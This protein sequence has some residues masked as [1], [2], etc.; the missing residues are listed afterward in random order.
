MAAE[1]TMTQ[2]ANLYKPTPTFWRLWCMW[3]ERSLLNWTGVCLDLCKGDTQITTVFSY[4]SLKY[5][6]CNF[7]IFPPYIINKL[8]PAKETCMF[9]ANP[10][11]KLWVQ[12]SQICP[13]L[14]CQ[15]ARRLSSVWGPKNH[16][17]VLGSYPEG[18]FPGQCISPIMSAKAKEKERAVH[19][20]SLVCL[21]GL[22][23]R[24]GSHGAPQN[25]VT[26]INFLA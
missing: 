21:Q 15:L 24:G 3:R 19:C 2:Q 10:G 26:G 1:L 12:R 5:K 6:H 20:C 8:P 13:E 25:W 23:V 11:G 9:R 17:R 18:P 22:T 4:C 16:S 14:F 7:F